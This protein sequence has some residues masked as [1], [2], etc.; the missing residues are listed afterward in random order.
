MCSS[1]Y[2]KR[3]RSSSF[4]DESRQSTPHRAHFLVILSNVQLPVN[5]PRSIV[6]RK[7]GSLKRLLAGH[8]ADQQNLLDIMI[9][10]AYTPYFLSKQEMTCI[11]RLHPV[12][13]HSHRHGDYR[14]DQWRLRIIVKNTQHY[15][16]NGLCIRVAITVWF[17]T[18]PV[19]RS[20]RRIGIVG[21]VRIVVETTE[22]RVSDT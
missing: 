3:A 15:G 6:N 1:D 11:A 20:T 22:H 10:I 19:I 9:P 17:G 21:A 13:Y 14:L 18:C 4:Y 7:G 12:L 8:N 16:G 2:R 5:R